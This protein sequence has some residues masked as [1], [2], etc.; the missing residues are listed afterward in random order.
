VAGLDSETSVR[1][2]FHTFD[3]EEPRAGQAPRRPRSVLAVFLVLGLVG[4]ACLFGAGLPATGALQALFARAEGLQVTPARAAHKPAMV[5]NRGGAPVMDETVIQK[6]LAGELEQEG[7]ENHWM[8]EAGWAEWLDK[9][10]ESSYNMN[11]RPSQIGNENYFTP[12][13]FSNPLDVLTKYFSSI[14][15]A[16]G[17]P[18]DVAFP[19]ISNDVTGKRSFPKGSSEIDARTIKPKIKDFNKDMRITGIPGYNVFGAPGSKSDIPAVGG[20]EGGFSL[21]GGKDK[22]DKKGGFKNPFR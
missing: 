11:Q 2:M 9:N 13:A 19:T 14:K 20:K 16:S 6:A 3:V 5:A 4:A 12:T 21:F 15:E 8:S 18:L 10:A 22:D 1:T 7:A 17:R